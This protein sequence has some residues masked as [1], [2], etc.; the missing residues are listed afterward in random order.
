MKP[1][2]IFLL[3]SSVL[4]GCAGVP[5]PEGE[6]CYFNAKGSKGPYNL[7]FNLATDYTTDGEKKQ[8]AKGRR[9]YLMVQDG[10]QKVQCRTTE[11][12]YQALLTMMHARNNMTPESAASLKAFLLKQRSRCEGK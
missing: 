6:G 9:D 5:G 4:V 7:C 8:E 1:P 12:C 11:E 3:A 2:V 10:E